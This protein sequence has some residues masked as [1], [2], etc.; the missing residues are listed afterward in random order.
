MWQT[1][2]TFSHHQNRNALKCLLHWDSGGE[3]DLKWQLLCPVL[4]SGVDP[5]AVDGC[6]PVAE[7]SCPGKT[8]LSKDVFHSSFLPMRED[9]E[10]KQNKE[11]LGRKRTFTYMFIVWV[12]KFTLLEI[13][14]SIPPK[15]WSHWS[16]QK[17]KGLHNKMIWWG[18]VTKKKRKIKGEGGSCTCLERQP[19][20]LFF[21]Q[22][23]A[24][25]MYIVAPRQIKKWTTAEKGNTSRTLCC[26]GSVG[27]PERSTAVKYF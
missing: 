12:F 22:N 16:W 5:Q 7:L 10:K 27:N 11:A 21:R 3:I 6:K 4:Q 20:L 23:A 1:L 25:W 17:R 9:F 13:K 15:K 2:I 14:K 19:L 18:A 8:F 26:C 24:F